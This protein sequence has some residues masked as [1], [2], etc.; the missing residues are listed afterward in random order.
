VDLNGYALEQVVEARLSERR[1]EAARHA[2]L[3]PLRM[4]SPG[5]L[6]TLASAL[7]RTGRRVSRRGI[8]SPRPA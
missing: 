5:L 2:L 1:A 6:A 7:I 8:V 3:V 4:E